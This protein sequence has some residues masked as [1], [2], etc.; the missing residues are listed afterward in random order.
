MLE[1]RSLRIQR[2]GDMRG[3]DVEIGDVR[4]R[5]V[6][7][8]DRRCGDRRCGESAVLWQFRIDNTGSGQKVRS[9]LSIEVN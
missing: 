1:V 4:C 9:G 7:C 6:R 5:D 8:G 2:Y 3:R